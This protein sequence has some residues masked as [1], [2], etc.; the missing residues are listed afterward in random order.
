MTNITYRTETVPELAGNPLTEALP[1]RR[2]PT[3]VISAMME[4]RPYS[5]DQ[6]RE[7]V[8]DRLSCLQTILRLYQPSEKDVEL[9]Y[10]IERALYWGYADRNPMEG[11]FAELVNEE[12]Q[13]FKNN[14][15]VVQYSSFRPVSSGFALIGISGLGKSSSVRKC[16][17]LFPQIIRH[18]KYGSISFHETP[19]VWIQLDCPSDGGLKGL[20]G[21]FFECIDTLLGTDYSAQYDEKRT[22]LN[23]MRI[24]MNRIVRNYHVGMLVI[25]EI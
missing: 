19:I 1:P 12:Y 25:D 2:N 8:E 6:R 14:E 3:E 13:A 15:I 4:R 20:C 22:T 24:A 18:Q 11:G 23:K 9:Y 16:L 10:Q 5:Q 7:S 21:S 17:S